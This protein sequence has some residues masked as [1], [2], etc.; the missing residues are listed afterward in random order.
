MDAV[1]ATVHNRRTATF[2]KSKARSATLTAALRQ[3]TRMARARDGF[4]GE[5]SFID[6]ISRS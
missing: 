1:R 4:P 6:T 2:E 5:E 3:G